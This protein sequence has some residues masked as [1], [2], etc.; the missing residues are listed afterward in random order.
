[1]LWSYDDRFHAF[2]ECKPTECKMM[3]PPGSNAHTTCHFLQS[4]KWPCSAPRRYHHE[5]LVKHT[6]AEIEAGRF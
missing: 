1:M 5:E 6:P 2:V 3:V 4:N